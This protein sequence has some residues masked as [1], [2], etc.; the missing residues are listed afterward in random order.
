MSNVI[1]TIAVGGNYWG[2]MALNL[3][4]SIKANSPN[5]K[6]ALIY[7]DDAFAGIEPY[8]DRFFDSAYRIF[9]DECKNPIELAFKTKTQLYDICQKMYPFASSFIFLDADTI[10][11]PDKK[12]EEWFEQ[13][14]E[15]DFTS[16]C[17]DTYYYATKTRKRKDYT[18]WCDPEAV[19]PYFGIHKSAKIPQINSSFLYWQIS[20]SANALFG[21]SKELWEA[22]YEGVQ[23]YKGEKPDEFCFNVA[24][25]ITGVYPHNNTYRP[26]FFSVFSEQHCSEYIHHFFK[27]F[28]LCGSGRQMEYIINMYN[29]HV[30]YY[31]EH[32][33]IVAKF[34]LDIEKDDFKDPSPLDIHPFRKRTLYRQGEL[35]NSEAGI[36]NPSGVVLKD[37]RVTIFRKEKS[38]DAYRKYKNSSAIPHLH[39]LTEKEEY[40]CEL[41]L[42]GYDDGIRVEDFRL[43]MCN[44]IIMCSHS[45]VTRNNTPEMN[46]SIRLS[47]INEN[48]LCNIGE[49][50]LP[51]QTGTIEKNWA[52]FGEGNRMWC[53]YSLSPYQIFYAD[54]ADGWGEWKEH[55]ALQPG[56][57]F[58]HKGLISNSTNPVLIDGE[59]VMMFHTKENGIY[60]KGA[61]IIDA[62]TK[63]I[64]H[65]TKHTIPFSARNDGMHKGL[66]YVSGM[67]YLPKENLIRVWYGE[68]DSHAGY[69]D[70][71]KDKFINAIKY[72]TSE[73]I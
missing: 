73:N 22:D 57:D 28:G 59:Y 40:E 16:Y 1:V 6:I 65:Y 53:I 12:V 60:Y 21:A 19:K 55:K 8:A 38:F 67:A 42:M 39:V 41:G 71:E 20:E 37:K 24:S 29:Q 34:A 51:I 48:M 9:Y 54:A 69:F 25:A 15:R 46:I 43:F 11:L 5:Q 10:I 66:H 26:L 44:Q 32:F 3:A 30:A 47:Y 4:L 72:G 61:V 36:F 70:Y 27:G 31:R 45:V 50:N 58:I 56:I 7:S 52:F 2:N 33:G 64:T 14:K 13:H 35:D 63:N 62:A 68:N 49:V 18:F 17:N 23:L